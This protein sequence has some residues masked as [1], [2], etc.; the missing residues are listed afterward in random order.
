M[1]PGWFLLFLFLMIELFFVTLLCLPM[2]S[3]E[4]RGHIT[5][6]VTSLWD[7]QLVQYIVYFLL[8]IDVL[9][10]YFVCD[11]LLHPL[12]DLG[13]LSPVEMGVSCEQKQDL[14]Y[15]ERNAYIAGGSI[16]LFFVLNRLVD[17]QDKLHKQRNV[18][19]MS[20]LAEKEKE[21]NKKSN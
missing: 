16:F 4:I 5:S 19:K 9:Y 6:L 14:F 13:I 20:K 8:A 18:V 21:A 3:N 10:F 15:N 7:N 11:A 12:Y 1:D 2:P 17:I